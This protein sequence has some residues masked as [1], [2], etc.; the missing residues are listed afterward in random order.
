MSWRWTRRQETVLVSIN[1]DRPFL[2][3]SSLQAVMAGGGR[4]RA[5]YHPVIELDGVLTSVI[6]LVCDTMSCAKSRQKL[7]DSLRETFAQGALAVRDWKV[8]LARLAAARTDLTRNPPFIAGKRA[9]LTEDL[10]FLDWLADNHFT[11][12][13]ARDYILGKDGAN[14][15]LEPVKGSGLGVLSDEHTRV[16]RRGGER[17]GLTPEVRAFLDAPDPIIVTKSATRSLVHR[18][19]H[20][21]YIGIKTFDP[22]GQF[23]G[24]RRFVGLFTS[25]AYSTPPR[26][27]PILRRKVEAVMAHAGLAPTSHNGKALTHILDT[28][29]RDEL[30]QISADE[31]YVIA[32]GI[33]HMGGLPRAQ[34]VP[35]LRPFRPFCFRPFWWRR[36]IISTPRFAATSMPC[37][38]RRLNGRTSAVEASI[39]EG[40]LARLHFIIGRNDGPLPKVDVRELE[41]QISAAA[42]PPGTITLPMRCAPP[43]AAA[44]GLRRL[45]A[46][47]PRFSPGYRGA[48]PAH[49]GA[50]DLAALEELLAR[51]TD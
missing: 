13:G 30:F 17:S 38:P 15:M 6:A 31:L 32:T 26:A 35:A 39:D 19:A 14:G 45:A 50:G 27:I 33:L 11:F 12:L 41:Q 29:P 10:A 7:I 37:W 23:I 5:A 47:A 9:D 1:D 42:S 46:L 28:F 22:N 21:D 43:M 48:F 25:N 16:I 36:A 18:R 20:M 4:I 49:E 3:D 24:E 44:E 8:M 2:F 51:M 34:A 40:A